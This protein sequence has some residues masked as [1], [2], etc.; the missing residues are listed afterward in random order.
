MA[1]PYSMPVMS[2]SDG[3]STRVAGRPLVITIMRDR[4]MA[5]QI[6][7]E[8]D[9]GGTRDS[10]V[11]YGRERPFAALCRRSILRG[12]VPAQL[13]RVGRCLPSSADL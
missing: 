7:T 9:S 11:G 2:S 6:S 1:G 12:G 5:Q 8:A 4:D 13:L 10:F 3:H